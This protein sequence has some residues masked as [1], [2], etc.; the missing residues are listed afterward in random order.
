VKVFDESAR[1]SY[2]LTPLGRT[3]VSQ[4]GARTHHSRACE[5]DTVRE[6]YPT[7]LVEV[8]SIRECVG[9]KREGYEEGV[10]SSSSLG[11]MALGNQPSQRLSS[12][13]S[14]PLRWT[15]C[16]GAPNYYRGSVL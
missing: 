7:E 11:R 12:M 8:S 4:G 5:R 16:I 2:Y 15:G 3:T 1:A 6:E 10:C 9:P 14:G 13:L